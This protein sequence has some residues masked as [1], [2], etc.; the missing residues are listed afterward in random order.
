MYIFYIT[1]TNNI[2]AR[3][4]SDVKNIVL[5][6]ING[7]ILLREMQLN[8]VLFFLNI[9]DIYIYLPI[10]F[11]ISFS[12]DI[13]CSLFD[14]KKSWKGALKTCKF[15]RVWIPCEYCSIEMHWLRDC[16][17]CNEFLKRANIFQKSAL[18]ILKSLGLKYEGWK[19]FRKMVYYQFS[20]HRKKFVFH[21]MREKWM[22]LL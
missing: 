17:V 15:E 3:R 14:K 18:N 21:I 8:L 19:S 22:K 16:H 7:N 9:Y 12:I 4:V 11:L 10:I 1:N 13:I 20:V 2:I 5:L 6:N